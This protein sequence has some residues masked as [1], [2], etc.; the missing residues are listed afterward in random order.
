M[1]LVVSFVVGTAEHHKNLGQNLL[2]AGIA[3]A[4]AM[5]VIRYAERPKV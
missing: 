4:V 1:L 2:T 5:L 3:C